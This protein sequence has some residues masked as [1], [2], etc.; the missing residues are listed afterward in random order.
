MSSYDAIP[1]R[2]SLSESS[3]DSDSRKNQ[4]FDMRLLA[5]SL[6]NNSPMRQEPGS[7]EEALH[8]LSSI[9]EDYQGQYPELQKLEEQIIVLDRLLKVNM[10]DSYRCFKVYYSFNKVQS[11]ITVILF[12]VTEVY[13]SPNSF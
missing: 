9:L 5:D 1:T 3:P 11:I 13:Q 6:E 4:L 12:D 8:N 2:N 10:Y 7:I